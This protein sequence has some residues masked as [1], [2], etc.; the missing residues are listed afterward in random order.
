MVLVW[1]VKKAG[2]IFWLFC[3]TGMQR[4]LENGKTYCIVSGPHPLLCIGQTGMC[5]D[6]TTGS[7]SFLTATLNP[8]LSDS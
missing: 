4:V 8:E 1:R 2:A 5:S 7:N 3:C 6:A